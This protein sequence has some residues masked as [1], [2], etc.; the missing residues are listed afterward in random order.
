MLAYTYKHTHLIPFEDSKPTK[1]K[2]DITSACP[3]ELHPRHIILSAKKKLLL[4]IFTMS[5][6]AVWII[7][8]GGGGEGG[9]MRAQIHHLCHT[10]LSSEKGETKTNKQL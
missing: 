5:T 9:R 10:A 1:L 2:V 4:Q 7:R 3:S 8:D 6:E